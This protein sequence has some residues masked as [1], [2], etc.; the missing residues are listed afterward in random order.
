M[1]DI[2]RLAYGVTTFSVLLLLAALVV[3]VLMVLP[4]ALAFI[5]H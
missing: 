2:D 3:S 5:G 4:T 1:N